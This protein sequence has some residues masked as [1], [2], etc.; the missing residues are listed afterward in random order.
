M[1][2][3][4]SHCQRG[5]LMRALMLAFGGA[6]WLALADFHC[7]DWLRN[8][9]RAANRQRRLAAGKHQSLSAL[10]DDANNQPRKQSGGCGGRAKP[11]HQPV[12]F[13]STTIL[14]IGGLLAVLGTQGAADPVKEFP[15]TTVTSPFVFDLK[16]MLLLVIF[17]Y[18]FSG[19][20]GR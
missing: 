16:L 11:L 8:V 18:A 9:C 2:S 1:T 14:I 19:L 13:A 7:L 5:V 15:F 20:R 10:M 12:V 4:F 17:V 6:R 3:A